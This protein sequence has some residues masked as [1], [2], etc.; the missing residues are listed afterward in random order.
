[1]PTETSVHNAETLDDLAAGAS[2]NAIM[3]AFGAPS[4]HLLSEFLCKEPALIALHLAATFHKIA[5]ALEVLRHYSSAAGFAVEDFPVLTLLVTAL[6]GKKARS[7]AVIM[8]KHA[9]DRAPKLAEA[10]YGRAR[11]A[12]AASNLGAALGDFETVL[13]LTPHRDAP[14]HSMLCANA[15][16]ERATI[17]E[18]QGH[19]EAALEGYRAAVAGLDTFGVHHIQLARFL[20][21][22]GHLEEAALH[23]RR[24]MTYSHRYFPEFILP[25][26]GVSI[27]SSPATVDVICKTGRG[28]PV[29]YWKGF[30]LA[31]K[32]EKGS[33]NL[34]DLKQLERHLSQ[35]L[36]RRSATSIAALEDSIF[37]R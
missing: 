36:S 31:L 12:Q 1:M 22:L 15:H 7:Q 30:Y 10:Y 37:E 8:Y 17:L 4:G 16:W 24:C 9:I 32:G 35:G 13:R 20:R 27:S 14:A 5:I 2:R 19:D 29:I 6:D 3:R 25:S 28:E 33:L 26:L 34:S 23:Y 18:Q 21:R 11:L